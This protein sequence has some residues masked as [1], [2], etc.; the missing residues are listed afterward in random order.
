MSTVWK[1]NRTWIA[2]IAV[3]LIWAAPAAAEQ[4]EKAKAEAAEDKPEAEAGKEKAPKKARILDMISLPKKAHEARKSG[5][6]DKE[7]KEVVGLVKAGEGD[8]AAANEALDHCAKVA[9]EGGTTDN[10]GKF[11]REQVKS[12]KRGKELTEVIRPEK[13]RRI[14]EKR[15]RKAKDRAEQDSAAGAHEGSDEGQGRAGKGK[16][17]DK[18]TMTPGR[19]NSISGRPEKVDQAQEDAKANKDA[20]T[21]TGHET[22]EGPTRGDTKTDTKRRKKPIAASKDQG[23]D[24]VHKKGDKT[25]GGKGGGKGDGSGKGDG[26][27]SSKG[28]K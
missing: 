25:G 10:F 4:P 24:A 3:S 16:F 28:G 2:C 23:D 9:Q 26:K 7:V 11:V 18:G 12:G 22:R 19:G 13:E 5:M 21:R 14:A 8:A 17:G 1:S 27:S 15:E 6:P 20:A